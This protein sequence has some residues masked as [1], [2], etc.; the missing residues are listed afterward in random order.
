METK[1]TFRQTPVKLFDMTDLALSV[2]CAGTYRITAPEL[3]IEISGD[4]AVEFREEMNSLRVR[5]KNQ[6]EE[7]GIIYGLLA[8]RIASAKVAA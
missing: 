2:D 8:E 5:A 7:N 1:P 3:T 4:D 6:D